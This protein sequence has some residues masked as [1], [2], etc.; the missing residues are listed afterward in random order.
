MLYEAEFWV[1]V[2]FIVFLALLGFVGMHRQLAKALDDRAARIKA[3]L[4]DARR[5]RE[6]AAKLLAEYER[7]R[8]EAETEAALIVSGAKADAERMAL[9]AKTK[10]DEFVS[11][12]TKLAES[13]IAQAEI[14]AMAEVKAAAADAAAAAAEKILRD[15]AKGDVAQKLLD[16][17]IADIKN[18]FN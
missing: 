5:L 3:E 2:G 12:R 10:L 14:Q 15:T 6:E 1:A 8:H 13:K 11:R 17:S 9:E 7:K 18:K 16:S 4:D